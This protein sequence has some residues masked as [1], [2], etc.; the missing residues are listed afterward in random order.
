MRK[1]KGAFFALLKKIPVLILVVLAGLGFYHYNA[2]SVVGNPLPM[3]FGYGAA[4]VMSGSMEPAISTGDLVFVK[5]TDQY[6]VGDVIVYQDQNMLVMHRV[7]TIEEETVI[8]KGDA[9]NAADAP[10]YK[11]QVRGLVI[12]AVPAMGNLFLWM[13]QPAG[14]VITLIAAFL[15]M[16]LPY[17]KKKQKD[18]EELEAIKAE[19]RKL[20]DEREGLS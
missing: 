2:Q 17:W 1:N 14:I 3:P 15:L 7:Q 9:N 6:E 13:K 12:A 11:T 16:E 4:V 8:V 20:K 10:V 18:Q 5:E 19:I